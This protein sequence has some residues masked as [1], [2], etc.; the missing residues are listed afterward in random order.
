[1]I[2]KKVEL[3]LN[4]G[5]LVNLSNGAKMEFISSV[6]EFVDN[7]EDA[8]AS[9]VVIEIDNDKRILTVLSVED[10]DFEASD[11]K[12]LFFLGS[13][14]VMHTKKS[15]VGKYS[16]GFKYAGANLIGE[17]NKGEVVVGVRPISNN[18]WGAIQHIDY[19]NK[20][21]Y[22]D[23]NIDLCSI[24]EVDMPDGYNFMVKLSGIK[25]IKDDDIIKLAVHLG[26]RYREKIESGKTEIWINDMEVKPQDRLYSKMGGRVDYH[27]P[28]PIEWNGDKEAV[29]WEWS[30][31]GSTRFDSSEYILYDTTLGIKGRSEGVRSLPRSGVEIAINGVT[32]IFDEA[33][34]TFRNIL[35]LSIQYYATG[36]RGRL[37][38]KN[39][40]LAD[41]YIKGGNKSNNSIDKSF[42]TNEDVK[43]IRDEIK[44]AYNTV[45]E[46]ESPKIISG[47]KYSE[48]ESLN[49]WFKEKTG[50]DCHFKFKKCGETVKTFVLDDGD[51]CVNITSDFMSPF[52]C[53]KEAISVL[54]FS[55][56]G[57]C[58]SFDCIESVIKKL[59]KFENDCE[60][61]EIIKK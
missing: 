42:A 46:R 9:K 38:I 45:C 34:T 48:N 35:N 43:K 53:S 19:T 31:L 33:D 39:L 14:E 15:G 40:E 10:T 22:S 1:M 49:T 27:K 17:G 20:K 47:C 57:S 51:I 61:Y 3:G 44:D 59:K 54:L 28:I 52:K 8:G 24:D 30:D 26:V 41:K 60:H 37:N 16:Q 50:F 4:D 7:A 25:T 56:I 11:W 13:G 12:R 58:D 29:T 2:E 36:W 6:T 21:K 55:I 18:N 32:V 23:K 5:A